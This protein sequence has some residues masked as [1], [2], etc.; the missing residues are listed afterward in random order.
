[1]HTVPIR[2]NNPSHRYVSSI[3]PFRKISIHDAQTVNV[4]TSRHSVR[5]RGHWVP[6]SV[7]AAAAVRSHFRV[8]LAG[9]VHS[10][11]DQPDTLP[12]DYRNS[13]AEVQEVARAV[14]VEEHSPVV[15]IVLVVV[16]T[17]DDFVEGSGK[18]RSVRVEERLEFDRGTP[19]GC[20]DRS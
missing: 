18:K 6:V 15:D 17:A 9:D 4:L 1:M 8:L 19:W 2:Q 12:R 16:G 3:Q 10:L 20:K 5:P 7:A 14:E 13:C 11:Q